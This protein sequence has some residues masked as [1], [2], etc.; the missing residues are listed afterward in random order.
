MFKVPELFVP[1]A[2]V[3]VPVPLSTVIAAPFRRLRVPVPELPTIT[4]PRDVTLLVLPSMV[5][6]A[7]VAGG[8]LSIPMLAVCVRDPLAG[9]CRV[10]AATVVAPL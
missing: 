2:R 8:T 1:L 4:P 9:I 5:S 7:L 10:P 3:T 6:V